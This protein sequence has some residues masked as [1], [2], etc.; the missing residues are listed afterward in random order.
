MVVELSTV[1]AGEAN[2]MRPVGLGTVT[3]TVRPS[4]K[5]PAAATRM[6]YQ[7]CGITPGRLGVIMVMEESVFSQFVLIP[8][9][10]E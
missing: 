8:L 10:R 2:A 9:Y 7:P 4:E 6:W 1:P 5:T 3:C